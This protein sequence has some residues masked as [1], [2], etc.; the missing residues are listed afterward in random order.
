MPEQSDLRRL[1][2]KE[3]KRLI[4]SLPDE[5]RLKLEDIAVIL[6]DKPDKNLAADGID[7]DCLGIYQGASLMDDDQGGLLPRQIILFIANINDESQESGRSF[8]EEL[9]RTFLHELGH[10][11]GLEENELVLRDID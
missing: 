8:K 5:L 3:I 9:R 6:E 10:Y 4:E 1:A 2:E 7:E 11:L